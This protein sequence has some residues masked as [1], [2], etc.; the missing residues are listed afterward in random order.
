M[1]PWHGRAQTALLLVELAAAGVLLA[2]LASGRRSLRRAAL[3]AMALAAVFAI[4][5]AG[6]REA[7][8]AAGWHGA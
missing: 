2:L 5:E 3:A 4:G 6:L 7:M 8:R 1:T